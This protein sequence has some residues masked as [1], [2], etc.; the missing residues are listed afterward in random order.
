MHCH[1][2]FHQIMGMSVNWFFG[3]IEESLKNHYKYVSHFP[4]IILRQKTDLLLFS[5]IGIPTIFISAETL[6]LLTPKDLPIQPFHSLSMECFN[7]VPS[8][9]ERSQ[10]A[11]AKCPWMQFP[12]K[13]KCTLTNVDII[14]LILSSEQLQNDYEL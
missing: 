13:S 14:V 8:V 7:K 3:P 12:M 4:I 10:K 9:T 2:A 5:L 11:F 1:W 6:A